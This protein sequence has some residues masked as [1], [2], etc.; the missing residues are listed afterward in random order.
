MKDNWKSLK[1][2][3]MVVM[4]LVL[5]SMVLYYSFQYDR[6]IKEYKDD[7]QKVSDGSIKVGLLFSQSGLTAQVETSMINAAML[8]LDEIN[9]QGGINGKKI[10][11]VLEDY[12]SDPDIAADKIEKLITQDMVTATVGCYSSATRQAVIPVLDKYDSLLIYPAYTEGEEENDHIIYTGAMPNQ[13]SEKYLIWLMENCGKKVYLLG[14][15]YIFPVIC[16]KQAKRIIDANKGDIVGESYAKA[17][18]IDF[19]E[20][21]EDIRKS[22]PDFI[23]CDLVGDSLVAFFDSYYKAGLDSEKCPIASITMDEMTLKQ[24]GAA[25]AEGHYASMSYFSSIDTQTN[26]KFI[27]KY[28]KYAGEDCPVTCLAESTYN[29][30]YFLSEALKNTEDPYNT[31]NLIQAFGGL[32]LAA[33]QG[34]I[35]IDQSNHCTWLYSRFARV[36]DGNFS[37]IYQSESAVQPEIW[38]KDLQ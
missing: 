17:G 7:I 29:S 5:G 18:S 37:I 3:V 25:C 35:R 21:I 12:S 2:A 28:R 32:E 33:P 26:Q 15:D 27:Q 4:I 13:H 34:K 30:C 19:E 8:A 6:E 14:N 24:I 22:N 9:S 36:V 11:Y 10:E 16:N 20:T 38:S 31:S 23:Y 1:I